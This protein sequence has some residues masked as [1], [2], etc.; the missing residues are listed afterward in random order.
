MNRAL[1]QVE[2]TQPDP[3]DRS[4]ASRTAE[5][6]T[7]WMARIWSFAS[8]LFVSAFVL[9]ELRNPGPW[10]TPTEWLGLALFPGGVVAGLLIAWVRERLGGSISVASVIGFYIWNVAVSGSLP[11]GPYFL[12]VA[13]PGLL[14]LVASW[15]GE[16]KTETVDSSNVDVAR[17]NQTG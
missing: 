16:N 11:G 4:M 17:A 10:P 12:L 3:G 7:R 14:F 1:N 5:T 9:G 8:V 13:L 15:L 6:A 2:Q